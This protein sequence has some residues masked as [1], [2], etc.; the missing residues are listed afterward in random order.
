PLIKI[1]LDKNANFGKVKEF[2][3]KNTALQSYVSV[4]MVMLKD[5]KVPQVFGFKEALLEYLKHSKKVLRNKIT[6]DLN[7][8]KLR[9]EI[10]EGYLKALSIIDEVVALIKKQPNSASACIALMQNYNFSERQAKAI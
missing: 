2:L 4:N 7:K 9:L 5:G 3:Y 6:F 10:V 8:A 1:T